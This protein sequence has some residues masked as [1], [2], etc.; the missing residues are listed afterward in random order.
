MLELSQSSRVPQL[1]W[2]AVVSHTFLY[3][4]ELSYYILFGAVETEETTVQTYI[5]EHNIQ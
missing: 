3:M 1:P 4:Q 2:R 5:Q